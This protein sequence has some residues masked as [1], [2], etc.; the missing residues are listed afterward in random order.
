[1]AEISNFTDNHKP[2]KEVKRKQISLHSEAPFMNPRMTRKY[3]YTEAHL[4]KQI[5]RSMKS[6]HLIG[7]LEHHLYN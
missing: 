3:S 6:S 2:M 7:F 4:Q 1:M 5:E